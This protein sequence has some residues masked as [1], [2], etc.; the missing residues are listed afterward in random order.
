M[1]RRLGFDDVSNVM[2]NGCA[3]GEEPG[4]LAQ[5]TSGRHRRN[6]VVDPPDFGMCELLAL[7]SCVGRNHSLK[8][9]SAP[10][11]ASTQEVAPVANV[12]SG[13][14]VRRLPHL[15]VHRVLAGPQ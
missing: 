5:T 8:W 4:Y 1:H 9:L 14:S 6:G 2:A 11:A 12:V 7:P 3:L 13:E 10:E 15:R